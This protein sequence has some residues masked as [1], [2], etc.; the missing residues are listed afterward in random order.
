[1]D[2]QKKETDHPPFLI[3]ISSS[4]FLFHRNFEIWIYQG[5]INN[6]CG[7]LFIGHINT[8]RP[9][10]LYHF[11]RAHFIRPESIPGFLEGFEELVLL[12]GKYTNLL[13]TYNPSVWP[14]FVTFSD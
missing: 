8:Y 10:T 14:V 1:M 12:C 7:D 3:Q 9:R 5:I 2:N 11:E 4:S 6:A 13:K